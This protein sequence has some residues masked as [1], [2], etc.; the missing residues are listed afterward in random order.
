MSKS[1]DLNNGKRPCSTT[2]LGVHVL[3]MGSTNCKL[4]KIYT[5]LSSKPDEF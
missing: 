4:Q 3:G 2:L 1:N 5:M